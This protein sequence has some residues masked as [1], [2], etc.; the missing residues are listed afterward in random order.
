MMMDATAKIAGHIYLHAHRSMLATSPT[1]SIFAS[2]A[3]AQLVLCPRLEVTHCLTN[4]PTANTA[5]L[6]TERVLVG[7]M[8]ISPYGY[9]TCLVAT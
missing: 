5:Y 7:T 4:T 1:A 6:K 2:H 3:G 8:F 9:A